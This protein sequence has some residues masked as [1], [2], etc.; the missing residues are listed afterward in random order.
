MNT[1][2]PQTDPDFTPAQAGGD[3]DFIPAQASSSGADPDFIPAKT[4]P[5]RPPQPLGS[6][7]PLPPAD[8]PLFIKRDWERAKGLVKGVARTG[9]GVLDAANTPLVPVATGDP[10]VVV[11][12]IKR[13]TDAVRARTQINNP[14]QETGNFVESA[15]EFLPLMEEE[16]PGMAKDLA[17]K[18]GIAQDFAKFAKKYP[19]IASAWNVMSAAAKGAT[20][21][22]A[23][24][25]GQTYLKTGGDVDA[26]RQSAEVGGAIG[27][28]GGGLGELWSEGRQALAARAAEVAPYVKKI[29]GVDFPMLASDNPNASRIAKLS[30]KASGQPEILEA[31]Q[32]AVPEA[33]GN[34]NEQAIRSSLTRSNTARPIEM[35]PT[36]G[37]QIPDATPR[38]AL[39][40]QL[41]G[42]QSMMAEDSFN[43]LDPAEQKQI[44]DRATQLEQQLAGM[45]NPAA[46]RAALV[47]RQK[48]YTKVMNSDS[49]DRLDPNVQTNI[50]TKADTVKTQ[51]D[52]MPEPVDLSAQQQEL[53]DY[54]SLADDPS[55]ATRSPEFQSRITSQ[56][57]ALKGQ[58]DEGSQFLPH[59]IE[60]V[61]AKGRGDVGAAGQA[62]RD[63]HIPVY[64]AIDKANKG[65]L[66][67]LEQQG[68]DLRTAMGNNADIDQ[69]PKIRAAIKE[70]DAQIDALFNADN[71]EVPNKVRTQA[72]LGYKDGSALLDLDAILK[73]HAYNGVTATE[74]ANPTNIL[75]RQFQGGATLN[76]KLQNLLEDR[77]E[78]GQLLG[79]QGIT[80]IKEMGTLLSTP[81]TA[82]QA[83]GLLGSIGNAYRA[84]RGRNKSIAG[85]AAFGP[86]H[87]LAASGLHG[88]AATVEGAQ[89]YVLNRL[90][91]DGDFNK[92]FSYAVR[93]KV[94]VGR[95]TTLIMQSLATKDLKQ[96]QQPETPPKGQ[97]P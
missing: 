88:T 23:E 55:F 18:L 58:L 77:P 59:D 30:A 89:H 54:Q 19:K 75:K 15:L 31:R 6:I 37:S 76:R 79:P 48:G 97:T 39:E 94:P 8:D 14:D 27:G 90:A 82:Y 53:R 21:G 68:K 80:N 12:A 26:T 45:P 24:Q 38:E 86:S 35:R 65:A 91:T 51:L 9:A 36:G 34:M 69:I 29:F 43:A 63:E 50:K 40:A 49:F 70:N 93:N 73:G 47:A 72:R 84:M 17:G 42:N 56:I 1:P 5:Q 71:P 57:K 61:V 67:A 83:S 20:T 62:L 85:V 81:E 78:L 46:D 66:T 33:L 4:A 2:T 92:L 95:A 52:A 44:S 22:A 60:S 7:S 28:G 32:A 10:G 41:R 25:G 87:A 11:P 74:S 64:E 16:G 3:P 96:E 13:I